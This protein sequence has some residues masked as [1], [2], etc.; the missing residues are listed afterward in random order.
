MQARWL[1]RTVLRR[2]PGLM[3]GLVCVGIGVAVMVR[4]NLGLSPWEVFHQG[5]SVRTGIQIGTV[6]ILVGVPILL[7]W[8]PLR[9]RPGIGTVMN[10]ATIGLTTNVALG[11][12]PERV[13]TPVQV[14]FMLTGLALYGVGSGLYLGADLGP[15]PRDGLMTGLH[16]RYGWRI[17]PVRTALEVSVLVAGFLLGGTVG[18]GTLL[19]A[20]TIGPMVALSLRVF[21]RDGRVMRR[22]TARDV[23]PIPLEGAA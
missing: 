19:F 18:L 21:D 9:E 20:L 15:G 1:G 23:E 8:L 11:V 14:A 10:I 13:D 6:S 22:R 17:A 3:L 7:A 5:I 2:L 16:H 4:S 12:L